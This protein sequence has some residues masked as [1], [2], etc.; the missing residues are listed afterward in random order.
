MRDW[1][2]IIKI[3][4]QNSQ[5]ILSFIFQIKRLIK[6]LTLCYVSRVQQQ[7]KAELG[8]VGNSELLKLV[9]ESVDGTF[10]YPLE[11]TRGD[12]Y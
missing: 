4:I 7:Q 9:E 8:V 2:P 10:Y 6:R 12:T 5:S 1:H 3:A 11:G